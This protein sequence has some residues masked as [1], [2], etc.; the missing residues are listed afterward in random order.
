MFIYSGTIYYSA[1]FSKTGDLCWSK[2]Y[3]WQSNMEN[4]TEDLRNL[5]QSKAK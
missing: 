5:E 2:N 3:N 1:T 4:K